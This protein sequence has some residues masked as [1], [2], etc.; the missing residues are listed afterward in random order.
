VSASGDKVLD[1]VRKSLIWP[2]SLTDSLCPVGG[3]LFGWGEDSLSL[4]KEL[5]FQH[6]AHQLGSI[7]ERKVDQ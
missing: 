3:A 6:F 4:G 5:N 1:S 7:Y 2:D